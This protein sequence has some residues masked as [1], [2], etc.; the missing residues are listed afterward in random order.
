MQ[1]SI[2]HSSETSHASV[3][4]ALEQDGLNW[5]KFGNQYFCYTAAPAASIDWKRLEAAGAA[6]NRAAPGSGQPDKGSLYL[7][8]QEGRLFQRAQPDVPVLFDKGRHL[9]VLLD[10]RSVNNIV[11]HEARFAI[12]PVVRNEIIYERLVRPEAPPR[13]DRRTNGIVDAISRSS[14]AARLT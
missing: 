11:Q 7:V 13:I 14:F 5:L 12:R 9:L 8:T 10:E 6:L 4:E 1:F 3:A 2:S